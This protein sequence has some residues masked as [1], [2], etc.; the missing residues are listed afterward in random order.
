LA[1]ASPPAPG[2]VLLSTA[3]YVP[4]AL[5]RGEWPERRSR[6]PTPLCRKLNGP[7]SHASL[8][9]SL[10]VTKERQ[11]RQR[12]P[13]L[14]VP[15]AVLGANCEQRRITITGTAVPVTTGRR[16]RRLVPPWPFASNWGRS[17]CES[18]SP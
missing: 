8:R 13:V 6:K 4:G 5:P 10:S 14:A 17:P 11:G 12:H 9:R 16:R 7:L 1:V 15:D 18:P 3:A 2:H